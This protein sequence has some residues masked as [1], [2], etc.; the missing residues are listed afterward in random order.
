MPQTLRP[1]AGLSLLLFAAC[2]TAPRPR[3]EPTHFYQNPSVRECLKFNQDHKIQQS[4][5]CWR[6]LLQRLQSDPEF[7]AA[8]ELS[9]S[10]RDKI[11][12]MATAADRRARELRREFDRCC[13]MV[14]ERRDERERCLKDFRARHHDELDVDQIFE[15]DAAI[16]AV[17]E[18]R[19][20]AQGNVEDTLEH[21][22]KLLG[23]RLGPDEEGIRLERVIGPPLD[24]LALGE[25]GLILLIDGVPMRTLVASEQ[26]SRLERCQE[27]PLELLLRYGGRDEVAFERVELRCGPAAEARR[28]SKT[29]APHEGCSS[30]ASDAE[31]RLGMSLCYL[32][33]EG[34]IVVEQVCADGPAAAAGVRPGQQFDRLNDEPLLAMPWSRIREVLAAFPQKPVRF[35]LSTGTL[36][37]PA[38]FSAAA[39]DERQAAS[40]WRAIVE[41][42]T[43]EDTSPEP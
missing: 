5:S 18:A 6:Q 26:I 2:A 4:Q 1:A 3:P 29:S 30:A 33:A 10:D 36:T 12:Q 24:R 41:S 21:A 9:A 39:L 17:H 32:G 27:K 13:H 43:P 7:A 14:G 11:E 38:A 22:G 34:R 16:A 35:D 42:R 31:I 25:E 20:R 28:L 37:S 40:C 8:Q 15:V 23:A 19:E